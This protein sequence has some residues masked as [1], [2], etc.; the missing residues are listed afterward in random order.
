MLSEE[1][2]VPRVFLKRVCVPIKHL[3]HGCSLY[4]YGTRFYGSVF[5]YLC[6]WHFDLEQI[7][8]CQ[9][10]P[11]GCLD[12]FCIQFLLVINLEHIYDYDTTFN[13]SFQCV[14]FSFSL[15]FER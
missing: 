3:R 5:F 9:E 13:L 4:P 11:A 12:S 2:L 8:V 1:K 10:K 15:S 6:Y 14:Y 7:T